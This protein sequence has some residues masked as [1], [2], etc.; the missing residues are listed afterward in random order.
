[1]ARRFVK[2]AEEVD[3]N[4]FWTTMS[5]MFLGLMMVFMTLFIFA[6]SGYS[7]IKVQA[8]KVQTQ[9]AEEVAE[10]L[11]KMELD[12]DVDLMTGQ[13][14]IYDLELFEVGKAELTPKG[15]EFLDKLFPIYV[16]IIF[17]NPSFANRI[18]Y[19]QIQG[20]SDS[21]GFRAAKT[22]ED[23][24][25]RNL[26]LSARRA[27]AVESFILKTDYDKQY[28]DR[29]LKMLV[30]EGKSFSEPIIENGKEN[31]KK[32][33]R[34]EFRLVLRDPQIQDLL[35]QDLKD[36]GD[37]TK[38]KFGFKKESPEGLKKE[39]VEQ[40][41]ISEDSTEEIVIEED[42]SKLIKEEVSQEINKEETISDKK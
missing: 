37:K 16:S 38:L 40:E 36:K 41:P 8:Q 3:E 34:V 27:I 23:Q 42:S 31:Y 33:R 18:S 11:K 32:S 20:H 6:M 29:L 7:E 12:V 5:D 17:S 13:V 14:K 24:Y 39:G 15:K 19:I 1:M 9:V 21:Q 35:I 30:A 25:I 28:R 10:V 22:K 26:D 2:K 4:V